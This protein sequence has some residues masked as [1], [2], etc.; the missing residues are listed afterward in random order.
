VT[1]ILFSALATPILILV[2]FDW[3]Q[4]SDQEEGVHP[5]PVTNLITAI[6]TVVGMWGLATFIQWIIGAPK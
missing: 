1:A 3:L 6:A 4:R 2:F 5:S